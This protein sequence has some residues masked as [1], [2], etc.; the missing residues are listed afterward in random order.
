MN[1]ENLP[2]TP[3]DAKTAASNY[4]KKE[5][6]K[7]L[8][9]SKYIGPIIKG[10]NNYIGPWLNPALKVILGVEPS[11]S[12]L[13]ALTL[14]IWITLIT[15]FYRI[16]SVFSTFSKWVSFIIS[17]CTMVIAS[18]L[19]IPLY[20]ANKII[21]LI[22]ILTSWWMQAIAIAALIVGLILISMFSKQWAAMIKK[23]KENRKKMKIEME[24]EMLKA[25]GKS[26]AEI[27]KIITDTFGEVGKAFTE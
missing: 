26:Q 2:Q 3:E 7:I 17:V 9:D 18:I 24:V 5:W 11:I 8:A 21:S 25:Q 13:F 19:K 4:L 15:F 20:L 22:G 16:L 27:Q 6:G 10:Y 23:I 1:P 12:W 14:I